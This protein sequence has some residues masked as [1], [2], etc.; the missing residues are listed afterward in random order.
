ML[1]KLEKKAIS[2]INRSG[3]TT[4]KNRRGI[5]TRKE[6]KTT[7]NNIAIITVVL[8]YNDKNKKYKAKISENV[9]SLFITISL[10]NYKLNFK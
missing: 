5:Y 4:Y 7:I 10:T 8:L 1:L 2:K 9:L 6:I 3:D